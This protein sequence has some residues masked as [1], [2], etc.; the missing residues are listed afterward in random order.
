VDLDAYL[1]RIGIPRRCAPDLAFLR[2]M[3]RA[4]LRTIP[5]ENL[6]VL[7]GRELSVDSDR[8]FDKLVRGGRGG[9]CFEMNALFA[10]ALEAAGYRV[11]ILASVIKRDRRNRS[12]EGVHPLVLI[13]LDQP[14]VA[15][16]GFGDGLRE[17]IPLRS[18]LYRQ[19]RLN[20]RLEPLDTE[21]WRLHNHENASI[22]YYDF[23]LEPVDRARLLTAS[24]WLRTS[25]ASPH[26]RNAVCQRHLDGGMVLLLGR[27]LCRLQDE[28]TTVHLL[29]G[30]DAYVASLRRVFGIDC[31]E[32]AA[33]WPRICAQHEEIDAEA[34]LRASGNTFR[35]RLKDAG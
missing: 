31:P 19:G 14:Y 17:P 35:A 33:L 2:R 5:Y 30:A 23:T 26:L 1:Q 7:L 13:D 22:P 9:W 16:V 29:D 11:R 20:F 34:T 3:H 4:H 21:W 18:G 15:D 25:S 28:R 6:D 8:A 24:E 12:E 27:G 10:G 32:A